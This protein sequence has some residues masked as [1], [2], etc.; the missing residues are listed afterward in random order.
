MN[1]L[2]KQVENACNNAVEATAITVMNKL[3]DCIDEQYYKDPGFYPNVYQRTYTFFNHVA[4]DMLSSNSAK[5]YVDIEGMH[6]KNNFSPLKVVQW[7]SE[8]KHGAD[9]YQTDT[10]DFWSVFI[11]WCNE[12]LLDLLKK[13]LRNQGLNVK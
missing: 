12:N 10:E 13:N 1:D 5:I 8:S 3:H 11:E 7:A 4:Y 2:K 6:Y 9:Y